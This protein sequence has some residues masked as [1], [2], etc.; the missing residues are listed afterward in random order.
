[1]HAHISASRV[2]AA[3]RDR[4][5]IAARWTA[6]VRALSLVCVR[7]EPLGFAPLGVRH[8]TD[9]HPHMVHA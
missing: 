8:D 3:E 5:A 7:A 9:M 6:K 1:M 2:Q 4:L